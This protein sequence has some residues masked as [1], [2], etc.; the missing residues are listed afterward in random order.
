MDLEIEE[1]P[2]LS[3]L[4]YWDKTI[5]QVFNIKIDFLLLFKKC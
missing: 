5:L 2:A 4:K 3:R 1:H